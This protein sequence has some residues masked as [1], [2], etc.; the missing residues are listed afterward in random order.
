MVNPSSDPVE[1]CHDCADHLVINDREL[2][3]MCER[4]QKVLLSR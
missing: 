1:T 3:Y 4:L 2:D